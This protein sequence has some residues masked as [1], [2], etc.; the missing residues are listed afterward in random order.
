MKILGFFGGA[1]R[2]DAIKS[3]AE[4]AEWEV[5]TP[6]KGTPLSGSFED[7][8]HTDVISSCS[9]GSEDE[10]EVCRSQKGAKDEKKKNKKKTQKAEE[11][12]DKKDFRNALK[13]I[14]DTRRPIRVL[15]HATTV[16]CEGEQDGKSEDAPVSDSFDSLWGKST[17]ERKEK[18][19]Q[20]VPDQGWCFLSGSK[21]KKAA[22]AKPQPDES[23]DD[24]SDFEM[25]PDMDEE[26]A[27]SSSKMGRLFVKAKEMMFGKPRLCLCTLVSGMIVMLCLHLLMVHGKFGGSS[28]S[29]FFPAP[30]STAG[31]SSYLYQSN[32]DY[33]CRGE[34]FQC[35]G[36]TATRAVHRGE[37]Y[38]FYRRNPSPTAQCVCKYPW[39][40]M[41]YSMSPLKAP[42]TG[43]TTAISKAIGS[44][45]SV[46]GLVSSCS[47]QSSPLLKVQDRQSKF[48]SSV[49]VALK[50]M[51]AVVPSMER[52]I[53]WGGL[54]NCLAT[55]V[56]PNR[57]AEGAMSSRKMSKKRSNRMRRSGGRKGTK[58]TRRAT[59]SPRTWINWYK[60]IMDGTFSNFRHHY[61]NSSMLKSASTQRV[62]YYDMFLKMIGQ[63]PYRS[64]TS[65]FEPEGT[66]ASI[67][68]SVKNW[69]QD[70]NRRM[71]AKN[72]F[73]N[74][75][76]RQLLHFRD[77]IRSS[78]A[79]QAPMVTYYDLITCGRKA[80]PQA[81]GQPFSG[82]SLWFF[83]NYAISKTLATTESYI[84]GIALPLLTHAAS[85]FRENTCDW[86]HGKP[87][88]T[89]NHNLCQ[90]FVYPQYH[91]CAAP[92]YVPRPV[93]FTWL[94]RFG[95]YLLS[96]VRSPAQ[97]N[98]GFCKGPCEQNPW[99][100]WCGKSFVCSVPSFP[101]A[102]DW[103]SFDSVRGFDTYIAQL[104][105]A[106]HVQRKAAWLRE[107]MGLMGAYYSQFKAQGT[108][109]SSSSPTGRSYPLIA[110]KHLDSTSVSCLAVDFAEMMREKILNAQF[111]QSSSG[112][113]NAWPFLY[114]QDATSGIV[115][116]WPLSV[117]ASNQP[118]TSPVTSS[119][120]SS[121]MAMSH[122]GKSMTSELTGVVC[123]NVTSPGLPFWHT[124]SFDN[125]K[126]E[127]NMMLS[128][129]I[130]KNN[131]HLSLMD[132][133]FG[134]A[135]PSAAADA[136][137]KG[138]QKK[139]NVSSSS[140]S[141][142][143]KKSGAK[144]CSCGKNTQKKTKNCCKKVLK[145]KATSSSSSSNA[146]VHIFEMNLGS[147]SMV[148]K[149]GENVTARDIP[150]LPN[151]AADIESRV[152]MSVDWLFERARYREEA[153]RLMESQDKK[154]KNSTRGRGM[155]KRAMNRMEDEDVEEIINA[156]SISPA[157]SAILDSHFP[158]ATSSSSSAK[159]SVEGLKEQ[160]G[161]RRLQ[162]EEE[163][164][165]HFSS[166]DLRKYECA[167]MGK[168][169]RCRRV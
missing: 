20:E 75:W 46:V 28:N 115:T 63:D 29:A 67:R 66:Q 107:G 12:K 18:E 142:T 158:S 106:I 166:K 122:A 62:S 73:R 38:C 82:S 163:G 89:K 88:M 33:N 13:S 119:F 105:D 1:S 140:P 138:Q 150:S 135:L 124:D 11:G 78:K 9:S 64:Q 127:L 143:G 136:I 35:S 23:D 141:S 137:V 74:T 156:R 53:S 134:S 116:S 49:S 165:S 84:S 22:P 161:G 26:N 159:G 98:E 151:L 101:L 80:M 131:P 87:R 153:R 48:D 42:Y 117:P 169:R 79:S 58:R 90:A 2:E 4:A 100:H 97:I 133:L 45:L 129:A 54:P 162:E 15:A 77:M 19:P 120:P 139:A 76:V 34:L 157:V 17:A 104:N 128:I 125:S 83:W 31:S 59:E 149:S 25:V 70:M 43:S 71:A 148:S 164:S 126:I 51:S 86:L 5:V 65:S 108:S 95:N 103:E 41:Y 130:S 145:K 118:K 121:L 99:A 32:Q 123:V 44:N 155:G 132:Q 56:T 27:E 144:N 92:E 7:L 93:K 6:T 102:M 152:Q 146:P 16:W 47:I 40:S 39:S 24:E 168:Q 85:C 147:I 167:G 68:Q 81:I 109:A 111:Q 61:A 52:S 69:Y 114:N 110:W 160:R 21:N 8:K 14:T 55:K 36:S 91:M 113:N 50:T 112:N 60:Q 94:Q 96:F 30:T 37:K 154:K 3:Q 10:G 57:Y 72:S